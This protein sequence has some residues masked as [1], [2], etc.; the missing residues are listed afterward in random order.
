MVLAI[1]AGN[2]PQGSG[3]ASIREGM[4]E[5][6]DNKRK[7]GDTDGKKGERGTTVSGTQKDAALIAQ[8]DEAARQRDLDMR[9]FVLTQALE[10]KQK[11]LSALYT[12]ISLPAFMSREAYIALEIDYLEDAI[13][14][15]EA[16]LKFL[17]QEDREQ[18][19]EVST[20]LSA[21]E[22]RGKRQALPF[23]SSSSSSFFS[24]PSC[25]SRA[26]Y[27]SSS[28]SLSNFTNT[29]TGL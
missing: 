17:G 26:S 13:K 3:R 27:D 14:N 9:I 16:S 5:L 6:E 10:S 11:R 4:A 1:E 7:A 22:S 15:D 25:A 23:P 21:F 24:S 28:T 18:P 2:V 8:Q 19:A 20:F 29:T 12:K